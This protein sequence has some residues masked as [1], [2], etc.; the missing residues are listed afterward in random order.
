MASPVK[1]QRKGKAGPQ[2]TPSFFIFYSDRDPPAHVA[3]TDGGSS[4]II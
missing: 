1:G 3:P 2:L 4:L